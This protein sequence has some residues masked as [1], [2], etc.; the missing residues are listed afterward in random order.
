M[1]M[2][3]RPIDCATSAA[4]AAVDNHNPGA[5]DTRTRVITGAVLNA[6]LEPSDGMVAVADAQPFAIRTGELWRT[7][8]GAGMDEER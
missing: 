4:M 1:L 6:F 2:N 8:A 7:R 5:H 3:R